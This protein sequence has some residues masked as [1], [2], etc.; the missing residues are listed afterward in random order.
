MSA[1]IEALVA[2]HFN[3]YAIYG[4]EHLDHMRNALTEQAGTHAIE[5]RAYEATVANL[6]RRILQLEAEREGMALV[7]RELLDKFPELNTSNY[8]PDDVDELNAW[9]IEL[10]LAAAPLPKKENSH[11]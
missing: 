5:L 11:D 9:G 4:T 2:K 7:P 8:G 1:N 10:V 6:E 3:P